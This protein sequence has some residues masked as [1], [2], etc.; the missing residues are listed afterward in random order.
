MREILVFGFGV[1]VTLF[2]LLA[3]ADFQQRLEE[4]FPKAKG[5]KVAKAFP[6]FW[7]VIKNGEV[8]F[9]NDDITI[10]IN[11]DVVDLASKQSIT[12]KL[13]ADNPQKVDIGALPVKDAIKLGAGTRRIYVFSDPDCPYCRKLEV[14]LNQLQ[15]TEIL[16]FQLPLVQLHPK[17]Q[18]ISESIWCQINQE[19]AWRQYLDSGVLPKTSTCDNP[20]IRNLALANKLHIM[21]TPAIVFG[22]GSIVS[23]AIPVGQI[24]DKLKALAAK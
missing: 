22:D 11:G 2:A 7:S 17:A 16:V 8:L 6:G 13:K 18:K 10:M 3:H 4:K 15:D 14:D 19:K 24:N 21:G 5:S 23:G 1:W 12:A 20:I 9:V